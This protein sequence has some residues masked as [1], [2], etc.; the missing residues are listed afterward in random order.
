MVTHV[1][2]ESG[3]AALGRALRHR[4]QIRPSALQG[5][6]ADAQDRAVLLQKLNVLG[7]DIYAFK[8]S[9]PIAVSHGEQVCLST[10]PEGHQRSSA[11]S[12]SKGGPTVDLQT[13]RPSAA[14]SH[15]IWRS[16]A[17]DDHTW[18]PVRHTFRHNRDLGTPARSSRSQ[19]WKGFEGAF[20]PP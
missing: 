11:P 6:P 13:L 20:Q 15:H 8:K 10:C 18:C 5:R 12:R 7:L 9:R 1:V 17:S 16:S 2:A 4:G 19:W 14:F 3:I